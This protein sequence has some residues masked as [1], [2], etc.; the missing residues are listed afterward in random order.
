MD[1]RKKAVVK[2]TIAIIVV[3]LFVV[4]C[5][6]SPDKISG[7]YVSPLI[8][9]DYSCKQIGQEIGRISRKVSEISGQQRR[10]STKDAVALGVG[11]VIFWP[12]LFFMIGSNKKEE[13]ARLKG[14]YDAVEQAAIQKECAVADAIK[15][16]RERQ[17]KEET[18]KKAEKEAREAKEAAE[19]ID[20][21]TGM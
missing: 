13:L 16:E 2:R 3:L 9:Q 21:G 4:G 20:D 15:E 18:E 14:E 10:E 6:T 5:A 8:Y 11:L 17:E 19:Y 7:T 1:M 12:A